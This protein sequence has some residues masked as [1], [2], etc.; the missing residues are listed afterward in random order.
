MTN[1]EAISNN[2]LIRTTSDRKASSIRIVNWHDT[3]RTRRTISEIDPKRKYDRYMGSYGVPRRAIPTIT[4]PQNR[5]LTSSKTS[6]LPPTVCVVM[7]PHVH[8]LCRRELVESAGVILAK[9]SQ[10]ILADFGLDVRALGA[11]SCSLGHGSSGSVAASV[12]GPVL[13]RRCVHRRGACHRWMVCA[14]WPRRF[15]G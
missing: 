3:R 15:A 11:A 10:E 1:G 7:I 13:W 4:R 2:Y 5:R 6:S 12:S 9:L 8:E 14:P